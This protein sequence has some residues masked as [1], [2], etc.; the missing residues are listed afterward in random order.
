MTERP[1]LRE[2]EKK[3]VAIAEMT[4]DPDQAALAVNEF[5]ILLEA[6]G[7]VSSRP[8]VDDLVRQAYEVDGEWNGPAFSACTSLVELLREHGYINEDQ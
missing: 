1:S 6:H 5:R 8:T 4:E 2:L 3:A 7:Y